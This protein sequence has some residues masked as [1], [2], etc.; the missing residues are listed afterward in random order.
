MAALGF[1]PMGVALIEGSGSYGQYVNPLIVMLAMLWGVAATLATLDSF[2]GNAWRETLEL[3]HMTRLGI[4]ELFFYRMAARSAH[5]F[6][7]GLPL[8][9]LF[10][11]VQ[12]IHDPSASHGIRF[13][14]CCCCA[15]FFGLGVGMV[16]SCHSNW[17][18]LP[19]YSAV[20]ASC[21]I[22]G[23]PVFFM[24][25][26]DVVDRHFRIGFGYHSFQLFIFLAFLRPLLIVKSFFPVTFSSEFD[27]RLRK[28]DRFKLSALVTLPLFVCFFLLIP[29]IAPRYYVI[30]AVSALLMVAVAFGYVYLA[31]HLVRDA[32]Y[33]SKSPRWRFLVPPFEK[34]QQY[35]VQRQAELQKQLQSKFPSSSVKP[36]VTTDSTPSRPGIWADHYLSKDGE[37]MIPSPTTQIITRG[38][39]IGIMIGTLLFVLFP[40][41]F[42]SDHLS[43]VFFVALVE[44][45][46]FSFI[47]ARASGVLS[48][49]RR[50][51]ILELLLV[52]PC[53]SRVITEGVLHAFA[54]IRNA[55]S[56]LLIIF[57]LL[58]LIKALIGLFL[59]RGSYDW[60]LFLYVPISL[61][62]C[63]FHRFRFLW[64]I[65]CRDGLRYDRSIAASLAL[66]FLTVIVVPYGIFLSCFFLIANEPIR[67][68]LCFLF[69]VLHWSGL[70][71]LAERSRN[72]LHDMAR[73]I[74][75]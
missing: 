19:G 22:W 24:F 73:V 64:I 52:S 41:P 40:F 21:G 62:L 49:E 29:G 18:T 56:L 34:I 37:E 72:D 13:F 2:R 3:V 15:V 75:A 66:R 67:S 54:G 11:L 6:L 39:I 10:F 28:M 74:R 70:D 5:I 47:M 58:F 8:L 60:G 31:S 55:L 46:V 16:T 27:S 63:R 33:L 35:R 57:E 69:P 9:G 32:D 44:L 36:L 48:G 23:I 61:A 7:G 59:G 71:R 14:F 30:P 68:S 42:P 20:G 65:S 38:I 51:G 1:V 4:S 17:A 25:L 43:Y 26:S 12:L 50:S 53:S 45:L